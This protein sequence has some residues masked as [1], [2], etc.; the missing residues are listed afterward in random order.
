MLSSKKGFATIKKTYK[1]GASI[2]LFSWF[3]YVVELRGNAMIG[4]HKILSCGGKVRIVHTLQV[5][6]QEDSL[7]W[8]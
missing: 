6:R 1:M 3:A 2:N 7:L 5:Q 8:W 4:A